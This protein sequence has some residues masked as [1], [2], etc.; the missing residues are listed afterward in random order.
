MSSDPPKSPKRKKRTKGK[1][2]GAKADAADQDDQESIVKI[3]I[4]NKLPDGVNVDAP[5]LFETLISG[6]VDKPKD[7]ARIDQ[8]RHSSPMPVFQNTFIHNFTFV[9]CILGS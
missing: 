5:L 4:A 1:A 7:T 2:G 6:H 9:L 8:V 3:D